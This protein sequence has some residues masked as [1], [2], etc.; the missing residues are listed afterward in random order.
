MKILFT[1]ASSFTGYWF[2]NELVSSGHEVVCTL[3]GELGGYTG[4]RAQRVSKLGEVCEVIERCEFGSKEFLYTL[5]N[6]TF[7]VLCHHAAAV[8]NY[9]SLEY[10]VSSAFSKNTYKGRDVLTNFKERGGHSIIITG[11]VFEADEGAGSAP[12]R[13]FSP[14]GLSKSIT[15]QFYKYWCE[16][17]QIPLGKFVIPNPFGPY[18][19]PRFCAYLMKSWASGQT[20]RVNTPNYVRDNIHVCLLAEAYKRFVECFPKGCGFY[21][22]SPS[23]YVEAQGAF[24][25]RLASEI[26][27]RLAKNCGLDFGEQ[28]DFSEPMVRINTDYCDWGQS[29]WTESSAWDHLAE[30]YNETYFTR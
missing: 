4:T 29:R 16:V 17:L 2:V 3:R 23:G 28:V 26:G 22:H 18:E 21:R 19:E 13:A 9:R 5:D 14:Y 8:E 7:D 24:G 30:Y 11:S 20:P 10:D 6:G 15:S 12:L 25:L 1:G 27:R